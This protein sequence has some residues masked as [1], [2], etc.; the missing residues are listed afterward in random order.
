MDKI[1]EII[2]ERRGNY[3]HPSIHFPL[4]QTLFEIFEAARMK[5]VEDDGVGLSVDEEQVYRH[6]VYMILDKIARS[7]HNPKHADN[8]DDIGGYARCVRDANV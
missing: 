2:T 4:T 5:A 7:T 6:G 8:W 3:P 1:Q